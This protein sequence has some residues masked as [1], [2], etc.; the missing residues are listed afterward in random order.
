MTRTLRRH[1]S[2]GGLFIAGPD[3]KRAGRL[4][5]L[6]CLIRPSDTNLW[7]D[8]CH[9][10]WMTPD[11]SSMLASDYNYYM[12]KVKVGDEGTFEF[13]GQTYV[14]LGPGYDGFKQIRNVN[15]PFPKPKI[16]FEVGEEN[17]ES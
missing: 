4:I 16:Q 10:S 9:N 6:E 15:N 14:N 1:H 5:I 11:E 17:D 12:P 3:P 13:K 8:I 2:C 7:D